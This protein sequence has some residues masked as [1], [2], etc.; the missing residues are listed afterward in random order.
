MPK[1]SLDEN[2]KSTRVIK[3]CLKYFQKIFENKSLCQK[4]Q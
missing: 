4:Y 1:E 3:N 2:E